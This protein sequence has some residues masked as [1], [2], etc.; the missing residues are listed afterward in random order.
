MLLAPSPILGIMVFLVQVSIFPL[1][2]QEKHNMVILYCTKCVLSY[3]QYL[4]NTRELSHSFIQDLNI[5]TLVLVFLEAS[6]WG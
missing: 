6:Q 3:L 4:R 2:T 1:P 5:T